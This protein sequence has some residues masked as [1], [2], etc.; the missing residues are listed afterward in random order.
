M[1]KTDHDEVLDADHKAA[2]WITLREKLDSK[3]RGDRIT[4]AEVVEWTGFSNWQ[5]FSGRI[6]TWARN[7]GYSLAPVKNDGWRIRLPNE[8]PDDLESRRKRALRIESR[9]L[10]V[11]LATP[12][13]DLDD[14]AVVVFQR[15]IERTAARVALARHHNAEAAKE[16]RGESRV[17]LRVITDGGKK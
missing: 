9:G 2:K 16:L 15:R 12:T 1:A 11:A 10:R 14:R 13:T 8:V 17:P 5:G 4:A 7:A 6:H 3:K